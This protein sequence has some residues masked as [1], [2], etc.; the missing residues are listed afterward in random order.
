MA[1]DRPELVAG[2]RRSTNRTEE[3]QPGAHSY[4]RVRPGFLIGKLAALARFTALQTRFQD[5][6]STEF[7]IKLALRAGRDPLEEVRAKR[8]VAERGV[9]LCA[10]VEKWT[11]A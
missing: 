4:S 6:Q 5:I 8:K 7:E 9:T 3:H 1:E 2:G 10:V 11:A